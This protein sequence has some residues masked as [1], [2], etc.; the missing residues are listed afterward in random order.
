M[1]EVRY[2][3]AGQP[4]A[5]TAAGRS[6]TRSIHG[7]LVTSCSTGSVISSCHHAGSTIRSEISDMIPVHRLRFASRP[8]AVSRSSATRS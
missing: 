7:W 8:S 2:A 1:N 6:T 5:A 4:R 3:A